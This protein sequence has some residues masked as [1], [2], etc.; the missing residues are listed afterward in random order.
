MALEA[1]DVDLRGE[2]GAN[3][4]R[5]R[6]AV[7]V[8]GH[9]AREGRDADKPRRRAH[10]TAIIHPPGTGKSRKV[11]GHATTDQC[12]VLDLGNGV[13][14]VTGVSNAAGKCAVA[15]Q[16]GSQQR[17][18]AVFVEAAEPMVAATTFDRSGLDQWR[19]GEPASSS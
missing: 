2:S 6:R 5:R 17:D 14:E 8:Q 19:A 7:H 10:L 16:S 12:Q 15:L 4:R 3:S 11:T 13:Y 1:C 18:V 9:L